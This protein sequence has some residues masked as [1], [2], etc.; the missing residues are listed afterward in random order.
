MKRRE[1]IRVPF[2]VA[3]GVLFLWTMNVEAAWLSGYSYRKLITITGQSGAGTGYQ[4]FLKVGESSG[5]SGADFHIES[6][7]EN[8][9]N[10]IRF[11]DNDETTELAYWL[12]KTEGSSPNRVAY[13]WVKVN[14]NLDSNQDIYIYYGNSSAGSASD[15]EATFIFFDDFETIEATKWNKWGSPQPFISSPSIVKVNG[16]GWYYSGMTT[17]ELFTLNDIMFEVKEKNWPVSYNGRARGWGLDVNNSYGSTPSVQLFA[18]F[19]EWCDYR[20]NCR[21]FWVSGGYNNSKRIYRPCLCHC[22]CHP[23]NLDKSDTSDCRLS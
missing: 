5:S 7:A 6:H 11:T 22:L 10:D 14:D 2:L 8:F 19:F 3:L 1:T 9:P 23:P 15:G 13:F 20:T 17:D 18:K 21:K 4:V 12:E 16:D